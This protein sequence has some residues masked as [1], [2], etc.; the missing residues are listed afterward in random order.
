MYNYFATVIRVID[1][2]TAEL[3]VDRGWHDYKRVRVRFLDV[4]AQEVRTRDHEEKMQGLYVK[5]KL[6]E[7]IE[8]RTVILYSV[9]LDKYGRSLG[10]IYLE[11]MTYVNDLVAQWVEHAKTFK[12]Q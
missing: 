10:R 9:K 6:A 5:K 1:G 2:D 8:G 11:D 12:I 3:L 7:C 4:N